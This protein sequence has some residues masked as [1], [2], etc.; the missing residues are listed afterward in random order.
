MSGARLGDLDAF[1]PVAA[2]GSGGAT[3]ASG[4]GLVWMKNQYRE[5]LDQARRE[6]KLVFVTFTGY[7]CTNCHW[8]K[9]NMFTKPEIASAMQGFVLVEL[10]TDGT[11]A[12]SELNQKI[13]LDKFK[14]VAIPYYAILDSDERV[15]A[16]YPGKTSDANE[17]LAFLKTPAALAAA[18]A[19]QPP[20]PATASLP[21]FTPLTGSAPDTKG[22]VVV[23]NFWATWCVPC[24]REIP[25][26][27]KLHQEFSK[28]GVAVLG[29]GMDDEGAER[30]KPFLVKHPMQY[31]VGVGSS[32]MNEKYKLDALPV[33]IVFDR[34]GKQVKRFEGFTPE[35][36]LTAAIQQAK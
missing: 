11:D 27:N 24:I 22:K 32:D 5:A 36:E 33:T 14:T 12:A 19:G 31:P 30:I 8:M 4:G 18:P 23:V 34:A 16:S 20:A 6:G 9:A 29:I 21:R 2:E 35:D 1:V 10:Y 25:S 7:A 28:Q 17:F 15:I 3:A 13:E 26:F